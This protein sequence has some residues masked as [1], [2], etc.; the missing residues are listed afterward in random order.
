MWCNAIVY[1]G[2]A[3]YNFDELFLLFPLIPLGKYALPS[4]NAFNIAPVM[5]GDYWMLQNNV[6]FFPVSKWFLFYSL[7][8]SLLKWKPDYDV[9]ADEYNAAGEERIFF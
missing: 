7:K 1:W 4:L 9:A 8:T 5:D 2:I 6:G 3:L